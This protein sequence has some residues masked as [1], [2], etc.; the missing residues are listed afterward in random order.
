MKSSDS[1]QGDETVTETVREWWR[2]LILFTVQVAVVV[3]VKSSDSV[4]GD[5]AVTQPVQVTLPGAD[6]VPVH[7]S[8]Q[9]L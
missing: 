1:V 9:E 5:V 6:A 3:T 2:V 7:G 4:K 8:V